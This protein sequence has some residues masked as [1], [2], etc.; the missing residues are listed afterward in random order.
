MSGTICLTMPNN[1]ERQIPPLETVGLRAV[2]SE[3]EQRAGLGGGQ[4]RRPDERPLH[5]D[6]DEDQPDDGRDRLDLAADRVPTSGEAQ[7]DQVEY[8]GPLKDPTKLPVEEAVRPPPAS[9]QERQP[10]EED[11]KLEPM[12]PAVL[13]GHRRPQSGQPH[14]QAKHESGGDL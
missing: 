9:G 8:H 6:R 5:A 2:P 1:I 10:T 13:G 3:G 7:V 11:A 14:P 4:H 12:P